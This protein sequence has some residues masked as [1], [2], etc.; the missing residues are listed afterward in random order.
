MMRSQEIAE[1]LARLARRPGSGVRR[2]PDS[3]SGEPR[4]TIDFRVCDEPPPRPERPAPRIPAHG[5]VER[6]IP[7][8]PGLLIE[9]GWIRSPRGRDHLVWLIYL[10][11]PR[12]SAKVLP[13]RGDHR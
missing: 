11:A 6:I 10:R 4:Y 8:C 7:G 3:A 9:S 2:V 13:F 1:V 5:G 12:R